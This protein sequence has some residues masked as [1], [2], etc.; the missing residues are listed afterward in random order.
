MSYIIA[1]YEGKKAKIDCY[2]Y[3]DGYIELI[4]A[5][6]SKF[7]INHEI[8]LKLYDD[9]RDTYILLTTT[10]MSDIPQESTLKITDPN[11]QSIK[12]PPIK[13]HDKKPISQQEINKIRTRWKI[14]SRCNVYSGSLEKWIEGQITN[15]YTDFDGE[16]L[17]V[18]CVS[19]ETKEMQRFSE[20]IK[21]IR[22]DKDYKY[23]KHI[24]HFI[25]SELRKTELFYRCV[26]L[27]R[28]KDRQKTRVK[29]DNGRETEIDDN[30]VVGTDILEYLVGDIISYNYDKHIYTDR[31]ERLCPRKIYR[32]QIE[33]VMNNTR[34]CIRYSTSTEYDIGQT[35]S[36]FKRNNINAKITK[37]LPAICGH[38]YVTENGEK[39]KGHYII[40]TPLCVR[41]EYSKNWMQVIIKNRSHEHE[42]FVNKPYFGGKQNS[43]FCTLNNKIIYGINSSSKWQYHDFDKNDAIY[44]DANSYITLY[45][46]C[47]PGKYYETIACCKII[48][49]EMYSVE[50]R[51]NTYYL[52]LS[53]SEQYKN[54]PHICF[55]EKSRTNMDD[56]KQEMLNIKQYLCDE[57]FDTDAFIEDV[58]VYN[59]KESNLCI[60]NKSDT[61]FQQLLTAINSEQLNEFC[62]LNEFINKNTVQHPNL[63]VNC[64]RY[65]EDD[66][67][68]TI[69]PDFNFFENQDE[70]N[71]LFYVYKPISHEKQNWMKIRVI[72]HSDH[73]L[74]FNEVYPETLKI[75]FESNNIKVASK[76]QH[77]FYVYNDHFECGTDQIRGYVSYNID[78]SLHNNKKNVNKKDKL[79]ITFDVLN[80]WCNVDID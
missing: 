46:H 38:F 55:I 47:G 72:N 44:V 78:K 65:I 11:K 54:K 75:S 79:I 60:K 27:S 34:Q 30:L 42:L 36:R 43:Q 16:W 14:G 59:N 33:T 64:I 24:I 37:I 7:S 29:L 8:Q 28:D 9:N 74:E 3:R 12:K 17:Q 15:I 67:I 31:I 5:I 18:Q 41:K 4:E 71:S 13:Q 70:P 69:C 48:V 61:T 53:N 40:G 80:K 21:D 2:W 63:S 49:R 10:Q 73:T 56:I 62:I 52:I 19:I 51:D 20:Y 45:I 39:I 25:S 35:P 77:M 1:L 23:N 58:D 76:S 57:E 26:V 22:S 66:E 6:R 50:T 68:Q 32:Y